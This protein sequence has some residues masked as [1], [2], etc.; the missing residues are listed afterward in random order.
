MAPLGR[1]LGAVHV[2]SKENSLADAL[3]RL[4]SGAELPWLLRDAPRTILSSRD[5]SQWRILGRES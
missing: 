3:S 4:A 2:S 1:E 5:G